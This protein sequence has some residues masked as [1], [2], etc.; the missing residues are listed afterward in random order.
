MRP[1][2]AV[3]A[4]EIVREATRLRAMGRQHK[5]HAILD[6]ICSTASWCRRDVLAE[7]LALAD[8]IG[9]EGREGRRMGALFTIGRADCVLNCSRPLILDPLSGH[10]PGV[11]H[12]ANPDLRGTVKAL[13]QLDGAFVVTEDGTVVAACR[14]L[15]TLA[16]GVDVPLGL[17]SRHVAAASISKQLGIV[18]VVVSQTGVVRVF[19]KGALVHDDDVDAHR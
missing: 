17:G 1:P 10:A 12:I 7:M 4:H 11:T 15:D 18:I 13:A 14:Y 19:F 6:T 3:E 16:E 2:G 8:E 9:R 5:R